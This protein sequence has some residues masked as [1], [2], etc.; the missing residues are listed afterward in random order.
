MITY[1]KCNISTDDC[2][3]VAKQINLYYNVINKKTHLILQ[4]IGTER[5]KKRALGYIT[6]TK[7]VQLIFRL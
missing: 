1:I 3:H 4:R 2:K 5:K 6:I 7:A